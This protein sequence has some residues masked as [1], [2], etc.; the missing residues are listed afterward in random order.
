[1]ENDAK[2][3]LDRA[4]DLR[5]VGGMSRGGYFATKAE[6]QA[7]ET[8]ATMLAE[9]ISANHPGYVNLRHTP[10]FTP[11]LVGPENVDL[12]ASAFLGLLYELEEARAEVARMR[13]VIANELRA[14]DPSQE[15]C[16]AAGLD[17]D[18]TAQELAM[19]RVCSEVGLMLTTEAN[20]LEQ[21]GERRAVR[22]LEAA[23]SVLRNM[24]WR[25]V[26]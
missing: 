11:R 12:P 26:F 9:M 13:H 6:A 19:S 5:R 16:A 1:M 7:R 10:G 23:L 14:R 2:K 22:A 8:C 4:N 25:N 17:V 24:R 21:S 20:A 3:H 18:E 15:S